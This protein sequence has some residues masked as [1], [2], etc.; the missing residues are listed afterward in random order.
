MACGCSGSNWQAEGYV[1]ASHLDPSYYWQPPTDDTLVV[2]PSGEEPA[3][4][5]ASWSAESGTTRTPPAE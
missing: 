4:G 5:Y 3:T 2:P 1:P